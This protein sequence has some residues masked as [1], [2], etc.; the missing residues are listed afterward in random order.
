VAASNF[1]GIELRA[2]GCE[3]FGAKVV[4]LATEGVRLALH[5]GDGGTIRMLVAGNSVR[6]LA[7]RARERRDGPGDLS[8]GPLP[9]K[10]R[11]P[12]HERRGDPPR[13]PPSRGGE[14]ARLGTRSTRGR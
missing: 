10:D 13:A 4:H 12:H 1:R 14:T 11:L 3:T 8:H 5:A 7:C 9:G 2:K 6:S